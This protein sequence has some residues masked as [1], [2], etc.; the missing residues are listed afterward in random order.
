[1][2][3]CFLS[4]KP[5]FK[6]M[7]SKKSFHL[8]ILINFAGGKETLIM[9]YYHSHFCLILDQVVTIQGISPK[10]CCAFLNSSLYISVHE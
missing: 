3:F 4:W 10:A 7:V 8:K 6:I 2:T 5:K 9:V 1:M